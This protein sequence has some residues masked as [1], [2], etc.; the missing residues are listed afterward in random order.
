MKIKILTFIPKQE[1]GMMVD[2]QP[3]EVIAVDDSVGQKLI[4]AGKAEI[5]F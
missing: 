1:T 3:N 5:Q 4:T 2:L